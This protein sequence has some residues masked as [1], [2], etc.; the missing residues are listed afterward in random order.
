M[1]FTTNNKQRRLEIEA[2]CRKCNDD[3]AYHANH[4]EAINARIE[5]LKNEIKEEDECN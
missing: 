1:T 5:Q 4:F 2:I 3:I